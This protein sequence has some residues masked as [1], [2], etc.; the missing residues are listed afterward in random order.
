MEMI[1]E[2]PVNHVYEVQSEWSETEYERRCHVCNAPSNG[3]H[4]NAPS[5][6][7]CA[8]FLRR[9]VTLNRKFECSHGND[10]KID[11]GMRV[12]CRACR[13]QKCI[14]AGMDRKAVQPRRD[15]IMGRRKIKYANIPRQQQQQ[16]TQIEILQPFQV[17][18][19]ED[20]TYIVLDATAL[21]ISPFVTRRSHSISSSISSTSSL[22]YDPLNN[23]IINEMPQQIFQQQSTPI[24]LNSVSSSPPN[25]FENYGSNE[26]ISSTTPTLPPSSPPQNTAHLEASLQHLLNEQGKSNERR[27]ILYS[28]RYLSEML[29]ESEYD[30]LPFLEA[31]IRPLKFMEIRRETRSMILLTFEWLRGWP[32]FSQFSTADK[33]L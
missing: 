1:V 3:Y 14:L 32:Y 30:D 19:S 15:S 24:F 4:F 33:V 21:D 6:S 18:K 5:C 28:E 13:Y 8:A 31:D 25:S 2:Q 16:Q 27:R 20:K 29:T 9:T 11:Y 26:C 7:A 17:T 12:I 23:L 10:C 22:T